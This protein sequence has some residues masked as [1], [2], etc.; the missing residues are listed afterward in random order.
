MSLLELAIA[1]VAVFVVTGL[2]MSFAINFDWKSSDADG[3]V[4]IVSSII[5]IAL[6]ILWLTPGTPGH[7]VSV[8]PV[9]M[10][11]VAVVVA[12]GLGVLV[13]LIR[14]MR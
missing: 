1:L 11:V 7:G 5:L 6:G 10:L 8:P 14:K 4:T 2:L 13:H 9:L 12:V 3:V